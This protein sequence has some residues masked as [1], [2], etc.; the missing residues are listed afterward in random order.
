MKCNEKFWVL[1]WRFFEI[2]RKRQIKILYA[3][4]PLGLVISFSAIDFNSSLVQFQFN[5]TIKLDDIKK[6]I[7]FEVLR[8][9]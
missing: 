2:S 6:I 1:Y 4:G 3:K 8:M 5:D 9:E 7:G